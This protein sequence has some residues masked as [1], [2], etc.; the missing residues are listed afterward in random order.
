MIGENNNK[1]KKIGEMKKKK[2]QRRAV[3][4]TDQEKS[5]RFSENLQQLRIKASGIA[6]CT[7][8]GPMS[9]FST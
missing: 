2:K 5:Q 9:N 6:V 1:K 3:F 4:T 8:F 7:S